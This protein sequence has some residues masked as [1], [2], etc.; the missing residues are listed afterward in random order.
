[1]ISRREFLF[2]PLALAAQTRPPEALLAECVVFPRAYTCCAQPAPARRALETG[3]F[4]HALGREDAAAI[5][6]DDLS[7]VRPGRIAVFTSAVGDG[8]GSPFEKSVKVPLA[9]YAP[10]LLSPRIA[11]EILISTIDLA[12][13]VLALRGERVPARLQ[14][15]DLSGLLLGRSYDVPDSVYI[16]GGMGTPGEWRSVIRGF[17]KLVMDLNSEV[18]HLYNLADDPDEATNL[19]QDSGSQLTR[20]ALTALIRVWKR[21]LSDGVDP[22]GLKRR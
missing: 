18:T 17:E 13:T 6:L 11:D 3:K 15:R 21:K 10:G 20:D 2:T 5:S 7:R 4:P 16:E 1:M 9:I 8:S 22:S 19:A 12:P 14:G